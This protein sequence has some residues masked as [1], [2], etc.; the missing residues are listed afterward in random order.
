MQTEKDNFNEQLKVLTAKL[1]AISKQ[2]KELLVKIE[3][4][5][6]RH[7]MFLTSLLLANQ[8]G[9][10]DHKRTMELIRYKITSVI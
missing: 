6:N 9:K 1:I 10:G 7:T 5:R 2:N 3:Q 4:D 8:D